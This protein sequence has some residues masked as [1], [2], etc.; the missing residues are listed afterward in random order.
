MRNDNTELATGRSVTEVV[1]YIGKAVEAQKCWS[2]GCFHDVLE[3]IET[4]FASRPLP[5]ALSDVLRAARKQLVPVSQDCL[6]CPVCYPALA[7]NALQCVLGEEAMVPLACPE[8]T[9]AERAGWPS[10]PGAYTVLRYRAPVA[11]CT[12]TD[13]DLAAALVRAAEPGIAIVGTLHTENHG[14]ERLIR[15]V[16]ANPH[17]RHLIVCG[18][19]SRQAV[20]HLPGQSL[21]ALARSG[22]DSRSRIVGAQ[23]KRPVLRNISADMVGHFRQ[24]VEVIDRIGE[25]DP[26]TVVDTARRCANQQ[27][28]PA[29]AFAT[30][31][32]VVPRPGY[33]PEHMVADPA[34]YVVVYVDQQHQLLSLEHYGNDGMLDAVLEGASAAELYIPAIEHGLVSRLDHAAYLGRELA[35]AEAAL[36]S[37]DTYVQDQAP[38]QPP[39]EVVP[40]CGCGPSCIARTP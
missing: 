29:P 16:V 12:L 30:T 39:S 11:V 6:G 18:R 3:P 24:T 14:I 7:T 28:G 15:N 10:L 38:E 9:P 36:R 23:G 8:E 4:A 26:R 1:T 25:S 27:P 37:G 17:I 33:V 32:V 19:D 2:C 22:L 20:G 21:V 34:G 5:E 35:R 31:R 13:A 40:S